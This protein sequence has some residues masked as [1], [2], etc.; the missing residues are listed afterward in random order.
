MLLFLTA[1][2]PI[3]QDHH[4]LI[5]NPDRL[6]SVLHCIIMYQIDSIWSVNHFCDM[7][8]TQVYAVRPCRKRALTKV[9][10]LE[11]LNCLCVWMGSSVCVC[12]PCDIL[13]IRKSY[14]PPLAQWPPPMTLHRISGDREWL[15]GL[16]DLKKI[17]I[18]FDFLQ[19][20]SKISFLFSAPET[21]VIV[22][23]INSTIRAP[24]TVA[25]DPFEK[26]TEKRSSPIW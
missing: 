20:C 18:S 8:L 6:N 21:K 12:Q 25:D 13:V 17:E 5:Y 10:A 4:H 24:L 19:V 16:M 15:D 1:T 22:L 14:T 23:Y 2:W 11:T 9:C 26:E 3:S 7:N